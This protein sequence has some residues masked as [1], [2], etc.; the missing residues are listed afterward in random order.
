MEN[1]NDNLIPKAAKM[2]RRKA[3]TSPRPIPSPHPEADVNQPKTHWWQHAE[4]KA[5]GRI[6][7]ICSFCIGSECIQTK[8]NI[9][10]NGEFLMLMMKQWYICYLDAL[11][12]TEYKPRHDRADQYIHWSFCKRLC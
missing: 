4:F 6:R 11:I 7:W 3:K 12:L 1:V 5:K 2:Y 9:L 8:S 10:K